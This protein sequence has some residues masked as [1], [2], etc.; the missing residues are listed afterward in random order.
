MAEICTQPNCIPVLIIFKFDSL[1]LKKCYL[2]DIF[3]IISL[4]IG[5]SFNF[6]GEVILKLLIQSDPK[7]NSVESSSLHWIP[8]S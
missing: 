8:V 4:S 6:Q 1:L 2:A 7:S 5:N 3:P